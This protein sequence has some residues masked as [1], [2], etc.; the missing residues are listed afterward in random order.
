MA[1]ELDLFSLLLSKWKM[2]EELH[3]EKCSEKMEYIV[4]E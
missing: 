1:T 3:I 2:Q 4:M